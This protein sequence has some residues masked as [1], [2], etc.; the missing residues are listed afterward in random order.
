MFKPKKKFSAPSK[1]N[2]IQMIATL[3]IHFPTYVLSKDQN[4]PAV[5]V[6][7]EIAG[8]GPVGVWERKP[9]LPL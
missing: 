3:R 6:G 4:W 9:V 5:C 7:E 2:K 1:Q 8:S